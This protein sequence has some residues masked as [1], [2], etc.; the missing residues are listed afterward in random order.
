MSWMHAL[1]ANLPTLRLSGILVSLFASFSLQEDI[2][3]STKRKS[4]YPASAKQKK[5]RVLSSFTLAR[6][7]ATNY[8]LPAGV[9][10]EL[11]QPAILSKKRLIGR[12]KQSIASSS[13]ASSSEKISALKPL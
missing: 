5:F 2:R 1:T 9:F 4:Q 13:R 12:T 7:I 6:C 10:S 3:E 8:G 11:R